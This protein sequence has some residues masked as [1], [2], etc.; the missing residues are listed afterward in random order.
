MTAAFLTTFTTG[1]AATFFKALRAGVVAAAFDGFDFATV[2]LDFATALAMADNNPKRGRR[3][4]P[5][6]TLAGSAQAANPGFPLLEVKQ[7]EH[8][9]AD[10]PDEDQVDR[11]NEVQQPRHDQDQNS[12]NKG[13]DGGNVR[14]SEGH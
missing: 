2:F 14:S 9:E 3:S 11:Y 7:P 10:E 13:N 1:L 6:T 8:T 5:Y 4:A 12:R